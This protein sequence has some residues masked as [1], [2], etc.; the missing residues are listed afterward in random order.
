MAMVEDIFIKV[1]TR[2]G[3]AK[4]QLEQVRKATQEAING[5]LQDEIKKLT[6]R[7]KLLDDAIKKEKER[8][9]QYDINTKLIK[10]ELIANRERFQFAEK[11]QKIHEKIIRQN[12]DLDR[13]KE[14]REANKELKKLEKGE[15]I[16]L[17]YAKRRNAEQEDYAQ[18]VKRSSMESGR[19]ADRLDKRDRTRSLRENLRRGMEKGTA[20]SERFHSEENAIY[21]LERSLGIASTAFDRVRHPA[22]RFADAFYVFQRV[23]Y[24]AQAALGVLAG[25]IGDLVGGMMGLVGVAGAAAGSLIAV[26]GAMANLGAGM[27]TAKFAL[28]GVGAAVQQLWSGQNQYNR[29]LR[30]AKKAFR[31]LRFEAEDAALSEQEAAIALEKA[32]ESLARVQ[33]LPADSRVRREAELD[34]QRA[35]LNYRRAKARVK[36]TNDQLKKGPRAG[37]DRSQDPLNNLT[38]SQVAFAKYLVT[39][40]PVI[41]GLKEAAASSFLPPLQK[42]IDVV[43]KNV[44]PVLKEGLNDI[45]EALGQASRNFTDAF[46]DK[47]NIELFRDFLTN[48]K[49]TLRILGAAAANAFGG[50]L[51]I[52][53]AAQPITDRFARWIFTVS[54]RFDQLGKGAGQDNLRRFFK[55]AG[56]VASELG[57]AFKLVF[58]GFKNIVE[59]TFPNGANSG[60]GGVILQWLKEIGAGFKLFTGTN[61]FS[62]W[63]KG[64]TENA[65]IALQTLG[66]FLKIFIDL[67]ANPANQEFWM[68]IRDA[69]PFVKKILEDGQKAG[70]AF[71][72]LVVSIAELIAQFS[73][74]AALEFFF[75]TLQ[76]LVNAMANFARAIAPVLHVMGAFHGI[77]LAIATV[78][79]VLRKAIQIIMG[80]MMKLFRVAGFATTAF[81]NFRAKIVAAANDGQPLTKRIGGVIQVMRELKAEAASLKRV[82]ILKDIAKGDKQRQIAALKQRMSQ[83]NL[84]TVEGKKE[85]DLLKRKI[86]ALNASYKTLTATLDKNAQSARNWS[87]NVQKSAAAA[88][89]GLDKY[90][91]TQDKVAKFGRISGRVGAGALALGGAASAIQTGGGGLGAGISAVGAGLSF[92]PGVGMMA[93]IGVS[94]VGSIVSGFEQ[95]NKEKEAEKE[96]KRIELKAKLVELQADK[97][98]EKRTALGAL[99]GKGQDVAGA[100]K[101]L[102]KI[103]DAAKTSLNT[104][105]NVE[106]VNSDQL[107][108]SL[109]SSNVLADATISTSTRNAIIKAATAGAA[110][111]IYTITDASGQSVINYDALQSALEAAFTGEDGQGKGIAGIK[112]FEG[113]VGDSRVDES[114]NVITAAKQAQ[115]EGIKTLQTAAKAAQMDA[116]T[117]FSG[118]SM[119]QQGDLS[120]ASKETQDKYAKLIGVSTKELLNIGYN[121]LEALTNK[122]QAELME[123][124]KA[125]AAAI[126]EANKVKVPVTAKEKADDAAFRAAMASIGKPKKLPDPLPTPTTSFYKNS[127]TQ[128]GIQVGLLRDIKTAL[129]NPRQQTIEL[130]DKDGKVVSTYEVS[131]GVVG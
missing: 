103:T 108:S 38:K 67:A 113:R 41:Q 40:K 96:Q 82:E 4:K 22:E 102:S 48:S 25:T 125:P 92:L 72:R 43:V 66:S 7:K 16:L 6:D 70:P 52:L 46:K 23:A 97:L 35:E 78:G 20:I 56:D 85:S 69:V 90:A 74:S 89:F 63:L 105:K 114:G 94:I 61:E 2:T 19:Y 32:R 110:S 127:M 122:K 36:D 76:M 57:K 8:T 33:D 29:A 91:A 116:V 31:D 59:A 98:N 34:F 62:G 18:F 45:G 60:A 27:M 65:K 93:G 73:D 129:N 130:K 121:E 9:S 53:K 101:T 75:T 39:L 124:I 120:F 80:I 47:E 79:I 107:V 100:N 118:L 49:P 86:D 28:S 3:E 112:A 128:A 119:A 10:L 44:F 87:A 104:I 115:N 24:A 50:I 126:Q 30:D 71:G 123:I 99:V 106:P 109:L 26:A 58:G 42:S 77:F 55:L 14:I 111:G 68:I 131:N 81:Q 12:K 54:E 117:L 51:A 1:Q 37:V 15:E 83:L 11:L 84:K 95:A 13:A 88:T 17:D 21:K 5:P 64:A